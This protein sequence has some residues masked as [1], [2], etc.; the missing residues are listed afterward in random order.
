MRQKAFLRGTHARKRKGRKK[1]DDQR[2]HEHGRR[3]FYYKL[4]YL[5]EQLFCDEKYVGHAN[6]RNF[7]QKYAFVLFQKRRDG[8]PHSRAQHI[9]QYGAQKGVF[10]HGGKER[11]I[12]GQLR[13]A[14]HE[15]ETGNGPFL[16]AFFLQCARGSDCRGRTAVAE[17]HRKCRPTRKPDFG[18]QSVRHKRQR[19]HEAA[20]LEKIEKQI[21]QRD[22]RNEGKHAP[23]PADQPVAYETAHDRGIDLPARK[24]RQTADQ[25]FERIFQPNAG[26]MRPERNKKNKPRE[27]KES[28]QCKK[29][30]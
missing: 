10:K 28:R 15:I 21:H 18:K 1:P 2:K 30:V 6:I 17:K 12:H 27:Q 7:H 16:N 5:K 4:F 23:R 14:R 13:A 19:G 20:F 22:L 11:E 24:F 8:Q 26:H 29:S 25:R 3:Y 9:Q